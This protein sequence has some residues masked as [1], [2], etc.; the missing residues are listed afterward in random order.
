MDVSELVMIVSI[1][2]K[3]RAWTSWKLIA[4][5]PSTVILLPEVGSDARKTSSWRYGCER[6]VSDRVYSC[7]AS[8]AKLSIFRCWFPSEYSWNRK[9]SD[10]THQVLGAGDMCMSEF[11]R[12]GGSRGAPSTGVSTNYRYPAAHC[13]RIARSRT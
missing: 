8:F 2:V 12:D 5:S 4:I 9:D 3:S 10:V 1:R 7:E 11:V 6:A 13:P